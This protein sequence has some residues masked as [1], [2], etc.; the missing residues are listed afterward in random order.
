MD[1]L[2]LFGAEV[3]AVGGGKG[4]TGKSF[5]ASSLGLSMA[6]RGRRVVLLDADLGGANMHSFLGIKRPERSLTDFFDRRVPLEELVVNSGVE[7][8]GLVIGDLGSLSV[9]IKHTQKLKLLRHVRS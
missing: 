1:T 6:S 4:G 2:N 9:D 7:G 5:L 3:W 8:L